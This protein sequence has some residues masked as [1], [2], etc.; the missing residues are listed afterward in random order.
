M[1]TKA[2]TPPS[3]TVNVPAS[4]TITVLNEGT[5]VTTAPAVVADNI[6]ESLTLGEPPAGCTAVGHAVLCLVPQGLAPGASASFVIPVTPTVT[7]VPVTNTAT[8]SGGG[9]PGC[10]PVAVSRCEATITTAVDGP[11]LRLTKSLDTNLVVNAPASY[12]LSVLNEGTAPTTAPAVVADSVPLT[13]TLGALPAGCAAVQQQVVCVVPAGLAPSASVNFVIPV[14]PTISGSFLNSARVVGGGDPGCPPARQTRCESS[15]D[16]EVAGPQLTAFKQAPPSFVVGVSSSYNIGIVNRGNAPTTAAATVTDDVPSTLRLGALPPGCSASGQA[17]TCTVPAG[18]APGDV[19]LFVIAVTPTVG[20]GSVTNTATVSGGGD[21]ACPDPD[22]PRCSA[23]AVTPV[24]IV[25]LLIRKQATPAIFR[26]GDPAS[27]TITVTNQGST[28]TVS[29]ITV[30]D[31]VPATLLVGAPPA[32][33]VAVG[34]QVTCTIP[35]GLAPSTST[36][37]VI[38]VTATTSGVVTNTATISGSED[39]RC[40]AAPNCSST[41]DTAVVSQTVLVPLLSVTKEATTATFFV[42]VPFAYTITV[43]NEGTAPTTADATVTDNVPANFALGTLPPGCTAVGQ[44]VSCLVPAGLPAGAQVVFTLSVTPAV[45]SASVSNTATVSGG[46]DVGCPTAARCTSTVVVSGEVGP[47]GGP[48]LRLTKT[49][50]PSSF[51][52][53]E[54][55]SFT[56]TVVNEGTG[57]T[58]SAATVTDTLPGEVTL[59]GLPAGCAAS[60]QIVTCIVAAGLAPGGVATFV[61]AVVVSSSASESTIHNVASVS[62]GGDPACPAD[63]R[64]SAALDVAPANPPVTPTA[65]PV[66]SPAG[67]ALIALILAAFGLWRMRGRTF[68][69]I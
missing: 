8:V 24:N 9:D 48:Q 12:T 54:S 44:S 45:A 2:T 1:I 51:V 58:T 5:A 34:N 64:C 57:P 4:Y 50:S 38:P 46:G 23:T 16:M 27:Y 21:P 17:V 30:T 60:G 20:G 47:I 14:T 13:F 52:P 53:G 19:A 42:G 39:P 63:A 29:P 59:V 28:A 49:A 41:I 3:F 66:S 65:I 43:T 68:S 69:G 10:R 6:P 62:G 36:S 56:L 26:V 32:G 61:L 11:Q 33:C 31:N 37:F 25:D 35:A 55:L 15:I 22:R 40:P 67:L 7:G 18:L